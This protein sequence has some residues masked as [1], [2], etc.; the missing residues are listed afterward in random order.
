MSQPMKTEQQAKQQFVKY[1]P[2]A[3][4]DLL[5]VGAYW[6]MI[7]EGS[8]FQVLPIGTLSG[9]FTA[10]AP[11]SECYLKLD[12]KGTI[13]LLAW[14]EPNQVFGQTFVVWIAKGYRQSKESLHAIREIITQ[15]VAQHQSLIAATSQ[16]DVVDQAM[17]LGY[18]V[19][20]SYP[21]HGET[22]YLI[23]MAEKK[24]LS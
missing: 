16:K 5:V 11:P 7:D 3:H 15:L 6:N 20:G 23:H 2:S 14:I 17:R 24:E 21:V 4:L 8:L 22:R 1:V 18:D 19:V 12:T 13:W 9:L 10:I